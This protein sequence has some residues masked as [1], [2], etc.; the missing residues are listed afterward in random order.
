M[1]RSRNRPPRRAIS[2]EARQA[3]AD[4]I[5]MAEAARLRG[6]SLPPILGHAQPEARPADA[7]RADR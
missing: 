3:I 5:A 2:E 6:E 1:G 7:S 4:Y